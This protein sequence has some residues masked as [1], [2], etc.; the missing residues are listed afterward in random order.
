M[1]NG[2]IAA[3]LA[4]AALTLPPAAWAEPPAGSADAPAG[5][6][7]GYTVA[8]A[9]QAAT[10]LADRIVTTADNRLLAEGAVSRF[11]FQ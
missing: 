3:L 8:D 7:G 10:L 4:S 6:P 5:A 2:L 9:D 1:R 11:C